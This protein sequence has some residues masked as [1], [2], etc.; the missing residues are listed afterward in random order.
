MQEDAVKMM[1]HVEAPAFA[2]CCLA[3]LFSPLC[4]FTPLSRSCECWCEV[5]PHHLFQKCTFTCNIHMLEFYLWEKK[6]KTTI[7]MCVCTSLI[8]F[9]LLK[10]CCWFHIEEEM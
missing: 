6:N 9:L 1:T 2:Q 5:L 4:L 7:Y 3:P 10:L 8:Q